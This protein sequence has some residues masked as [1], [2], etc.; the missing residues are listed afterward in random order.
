MLCG[1]IRF[2]GSMIS[3]SLKTHWIN[4]ILLLSFATWNLLYFLLFCH[5]NI[6]LIMKCS[7][8]ALLNILFLV[9]STISWCVVL[10]AE[11]YTISNKNST[12]HNTVQI[13]RHQYMSLI[14][15]NY[16]PGHRLFPS[17]SV[18]CLWIRPIFNIILWLTFTSQSWLFN[19]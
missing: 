13:Q 1:K 9:K 5:K 17:H 15:G 2:A 7:K 6:C 12:L 11:L 14:N 4:Y 18:T 3:L 19:S 16:K 8:D 10:T